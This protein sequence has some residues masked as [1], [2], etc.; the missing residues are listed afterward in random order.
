MRHRKKSFN[1]HILYLLRSTIIAVKKLLTLFIAVC[2]FASCNGQENKNEQLQV[3]MDWDLYFT[4]VDDNL[5]SIRLNLALNSIA[6]I[7]K[8]SHRIWFS[9][10]LLNPDENGFTTREEFPTISQ[11]EDDIADALAEKGVLQVGAVKTNGV[12]D[13]YFY[14]KDDKDYRD[15]INSVMRKYPDYK[16]A[17]DIKKDAEWNDYLTFL[18]P[19]EYE[20]QTIQN[21][22]VITQL[23]KH[24][25]NPE[26][27]REVDHWIYFK[28]EGGLDRYIQQVEVLGYK[29]LSKNKLT[30]DKEYPFQ[31]NISR[32]DNTIWNNVNEYTWELYTLAKE[33]DGQYDG[34]GCPI[35]K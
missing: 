18:Y 9:V 25:D 26:L 8:Y 21:Q 6:P 32:Q 1:F 22:K 35:A 16:Y 15:L 28:S 3:P 19:A 10:Q 14:S 2:A 13:L 5:A 7:E 24:G 12:L 11:I 34:W 30:D 27:K 20:F 29:V 17:T 33:N 31:V 4:R 23:E